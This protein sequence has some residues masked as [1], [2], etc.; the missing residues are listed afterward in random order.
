MYFVNLSSVLGIIGIQALNPTTEP[1]L[2]NDLIVIKVS[3]IY[4]FYVYFK[5]TYF[6]GSSL[7][8]QNSYSYCRVITL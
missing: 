7:S 4:K 2:T 5:W 6:L 1:S 3:Y 8:H